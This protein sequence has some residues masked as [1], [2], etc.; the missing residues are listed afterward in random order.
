MQ[1]QVGLGSIAT[2]KASEGDR[3]PIEL[4]LNPKR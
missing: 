3:I 2:N 1:S 4:F